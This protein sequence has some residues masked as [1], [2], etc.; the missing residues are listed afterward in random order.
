[1]SRLV[2]AVLTPWWIGGTFAL[3]GTGHTVL[4]CACLGASIFSIMY[5]GDNIGSSQK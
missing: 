1:M 2:V 5:I 3:A 4:A